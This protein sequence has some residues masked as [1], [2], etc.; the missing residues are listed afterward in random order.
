MKVTGRKP[1]PKATFPGTLGFA[2]GMLGFQ[3]LKQAEGRQELLAHT[4]EVLS[5]ASSLS[6][7][8]D[9]CSFLVQDK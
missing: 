3:T 9:L 2:G 1:D 5:V 7:F 6:R 4:L 8:V